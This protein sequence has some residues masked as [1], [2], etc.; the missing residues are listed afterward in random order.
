MALPNVDG[1][2]NLFGSSD[3]NWYSDSSTASIEHDIANL[4]AAISIRGVG[5]LPNNVSLEI[6]SFVIFFETHLNF[7][8]ISFFRLTPVCYPDLLSMLTQT[9]DGITIHA[10]VA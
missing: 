10:K 5:K 3:L 4:P 7:F 6:Y 9:E 2:V 8:G 1:A